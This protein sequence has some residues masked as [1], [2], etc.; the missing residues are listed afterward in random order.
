MTP[1]ATPSTDPT[2]AVYTSCEQLFSIGIGPSSSHTVGPMRAAADFVAR[3]ARRTT[4]PHAARSPRCR[5]RL[6]GSLGATGLGHGTPAAILAGLSCWEP[7]SCDPEA[8]TALW[9]RLDAEGELD[10]G[11]VRVARADV[12]L[13]PQDRSQEHPNA[14]TLELVDDDGAVLLARTYLSPGG[15]FF[16]EA[17][18][19]AAE[20]PPARAHRYT[21][22]DE[23]LTLCADRSIADV[24]WEDECAQRGGAEAGAA[25]T[26]RVLDAVWEAMEACI[27]AG[28]GQEPVLLPGRLGVRRRA[29]GLW[30]RV[31]AADSSLG[32]EEDRVIAYAMAVNEENAAGRRVVTAPTNGAA[33]IIPAVLQHLV[34]RG[35]DAEEVRTFLLTAAAV[36]SIIKANA[37]I[38]GAEAGCQGEVGSACSMAAAG[39]CAVMGGT[40]AQV[41]TAAETALE[42]H[43]GLTCDPVEGLVQIPCIERNAVAAKTAITS[44][45]IALLGDGDH[46]VSLDTAVETMRQTGEDMSSRYKETSTGGLAVN[47]PY[48]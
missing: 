45:R 36:G 9:S 16:R 48:C 5:I 46:R 1:M 38:S 33:G 6:H 18:V 23:L 43:L 2:T 37:S 42:H 29:S 19:A 13:D 15:G 7:A 31:E 20:E 41:E 14:L 12:V 8:V 25:E 22:M 35:A 44:A 32:T 27:A 28:L 47:V 10:L 26:R 4:A 24:A 11:A 39:M 21:R 30:R 3:A 17:G 40:P 34:D